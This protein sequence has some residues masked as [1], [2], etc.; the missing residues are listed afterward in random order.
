VVRRQGWAATEEKGFATAIGVE[1]NKLKAEPG[2]DAS[3]RPPNRGESRWGAKGPFATSE[4]LKEKDRTRVGAG[5]VNVL[6]YN[7]REL[8]RDIR[9]K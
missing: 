6:R 1:D 4:G 2:S 5:L 9:L 8:K 7:Q 3:W